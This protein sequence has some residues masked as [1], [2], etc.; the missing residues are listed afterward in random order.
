MKQT[1]LALEGLGG[2]EEEYEEEDA[3]EKVLGPERERDRWW[4]APVEEEEEEG[5]GADPPCRDDED[6]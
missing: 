6:G 4:E 1:A 2:V 3:D 5:G